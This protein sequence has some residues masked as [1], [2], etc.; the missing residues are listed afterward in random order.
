MANLFIDG[1]C[2]ERGLCHFI[3]DIYPLDISFN[4]DVQQITTLIK[5]GESETLEF[6]A[7]FG[8]ETVITLGAFANTR[9]GH[10]LI[11]VDKKGSVKG[12]DVGNE[13]LKDW[14]NQISQLSE[15][16]IIPR[17]GSLVYEEKKIVV[18]YMKEFP[19]KPVA[20]RGRCYRR[21][22]PSNRVMTP[23]EISEVHLESIG[24]T[25]DAMC[26]PKTSI[27]DI[28]V[29]KVIDYIQ[30]ARKTGRKNFSGNEEPVPL[31][32]K[33]ELVGDVAPTWAAVIAFGHN[34]PLQAKVKCG[35][36]R[37]NSTIVDDFVVE[38]PLLDQVQN[39]LDYM[40]RTLKLS[41]AFTGEAKRKEIWE[42]PLEAV[43]E[44]VTNAVCHRDY[45]SPAQIQ[46]K[47]FDDRMTIWNPGGLPLG[48]T[49]ERLLDPNHNSI[50]RNQLIALMFY[51]TELIENYGS[52]IE[53]IFND[54]KVSGF[55]DPEFKEVDG[56]FQV[57]FCKDMYT[58]D[59]LTQ[60][61]LS[62][63]QINALLAITERGTIT[64]REYRD[65]TSVSDR[66]ALRDLNDLC[67]KGLLE[68]V[69]KT[70]R[71]MIY[72]LIRQKPAKPAKNPP[73][74]RQDPK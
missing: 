61:D 60:M 17:I 55:P 22:G 15:P 2:K 16:T 58:R 32:K 29:S 51:D 44:A 69:G 20:I 52:G 26:P 33:L 73:K 19:Q 9:G 41:Y 45:S 31:L 59:S 34:P 39:V 13:A 28:D 18:I 64:N 54:C 66:T 65:L 42:Y 8:K 11:G 24:T 67:I 53:R 30:R 72:A 37:G 6:K 74:T 23:S 43:R 68:R 38:A 56:G 48:M 70:G 10:V 46:I 7:N 27:K 1:D 21:V 4:M 5:N 50:P 25:W 57:I 36:I 49:L 40:R 12:V 35:R 3:S 47:I 63:R 71:G 62:K 14:S